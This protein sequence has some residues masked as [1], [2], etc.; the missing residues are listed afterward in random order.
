[1]NFQKREIP[2]SDSGGGTFFKLKDGESVNGIC[3]GEIYEFFRKWEGGKSHLVDNSDPKAQSAFRI[4][5]IVQEGHVFK[6]KTWEFGLT[7]YNQLADINDEYPLS[8]TKIKVTRRGTG[9][10]TIYA[11]LPLLKEPIP[12]LALKE[13]NAVPLNMLQHKVPAAPKMDDQF[14]ELGF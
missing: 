9:T 3:R 13:I 6:A 2:K 11:I 14:D 7:I 10:D 8:S 12:P 4:N 1:M 5:I